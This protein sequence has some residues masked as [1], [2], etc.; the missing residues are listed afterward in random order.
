MA[1]DDDEGELLDFGYV[2]SSVQTHRQE[3]ERLFNKEH[4][5]LIKDFYHRYGVRAHVDVD[6]ILNLQDYPYNSCGCVVTHNFG[7]T[8]KVLLV[9]DRYSWGF[10]HLNHHLFGGKDIIDFPIKVTPEEFKILE[11]DEAIQLLRK[12]WTKSKQIDFSDFKDV[13][14]ANLKLQALLEESKISQEGLCMYSIPKGAKLNCEFGESGGLRELEEEALIPREA[15]SINYQRCLPNFDYRLQ[16][17]KGVFHINFCVLRDVSYAVD[18]KLPI[19]LADETAHRIWI[20][21]N[22]L[23]EIVVADNPRIRLNLIT[24]K[25]LKV[26]LDNLKNERHSR[27]RSI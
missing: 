11:E 10:S 5:R 20:S 3:L 12:M 23:Q 27:S 18:E 6:G 21:L 8:T 17:L 4:Q 22:Q 1:G 14:E 19:N 9:R 13:E 16:L 25:A 24:K 26:L 7:D 2:F 15:V